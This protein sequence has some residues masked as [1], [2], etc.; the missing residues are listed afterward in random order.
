VR[1]S[2]SRPPFGKGSLHLSYPIIQDGLIY[3]VDEVNEITFLEGNSNQ[4]H[5]HCYEPVGAPPSYLQAS[6]VLRRGGL[7]RRRVARTCPKGP[8]RCGAVRLVVARCEVLYTGRLTAFLP[9]ST[10]L[11]IMKSD[12]SVLVHADA[13]GYEPLNSRFPG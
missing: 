1:P 12:G 10:R 8:V 2:K 6:T 13:G 5:A 3:M 4:G 7:A 11:L 9:E